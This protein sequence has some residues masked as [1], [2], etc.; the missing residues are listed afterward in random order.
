MCN[1]LN[2]ELLTFCWLEMKT[3]Q[4]FSKVVTSSLPLKKKL[5]ISSQQPCPGLRNFKVL[6]GFK[7]HF[8][9]CA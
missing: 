6:P 4:K 2:R 3:E 5:Q 7:F 8:S 1:N 9:F